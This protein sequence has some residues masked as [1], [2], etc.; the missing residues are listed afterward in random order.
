MG[1][2]SD[3]PKAMSNFF[4]GNSSVFR[5]I[6]ILY[7]IKQFCCMSSKILLIVL[8]FIIVL[9]VLMAFLRKAKRKRMEHKI[10]DAELKSKMRDAT[11]RSDDMKNSDL[12]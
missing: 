12:F 11:R 9:A 3:I 1:S 7:R 10:E 5:R 8:A 6:G 4:S 2:I